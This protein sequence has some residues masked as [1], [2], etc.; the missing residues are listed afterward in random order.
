MSEHEGVLNIAEIFY[1]SGVIKARYSRYLSK[2]AKQFIR[3]GLY[4]A[5]YENGTIASEVT[6]AHGLEQGLSKDFYDNGQVAS[7]GH[8]EQGKEHGTWNYW[9]PSGEADIPVVFVHGVE[10]GT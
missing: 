6:Y 5:Y 9:S 7:S 2:D 3:H 10:S 4:V 8:Y 1:P